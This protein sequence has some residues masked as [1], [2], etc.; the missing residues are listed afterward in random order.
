MEM[1]NYLDKVTR[2]Q[3][4][5]HFLNLKTQKVTRNKFT[6]ERKAR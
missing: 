2:K 6:I 1:S 5:A 4:K 3:G